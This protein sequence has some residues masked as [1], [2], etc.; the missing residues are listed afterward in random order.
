M[1][2]AIGSRA[3]L[4]EVKKCVACKSCELACAKAHA[5]FEDLVAAVLTEA[6]LV[7]RVHVIRAAG[8]NV[9]IQCRHCQD[10]PCVAACPTEALY[11]E[12]ES[13]RVLTDPE[14][15]IACGAC[16]RVCPYGAI[17]WDADGEKIVKCDV[18]EGLIQDGEEPFCV[19][20]CPTNALHMV[21]VEELHEA[22]AS[23]QYDSL[24]RDE[25]RIGAAGPG[26]TFEIDRD[27]CI[28]CGR[29]AKNCP[30][31]C[32]AGKPGKAPSKAKP[33]DKEKGKVGEPFEIDQDK[34]VKCGT[35]FE[36][37]PAD[38]VRKS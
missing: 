21:T 10:A 4:V 31:D 36:V 11:K 38:A 32:I 13:G 6:R 37:C 7:P 35:C 29:C 12:E 8:Q 2:T 1:A 30:V 19:R 18:C 16:T 15:C 9:P 33:E 17:V 28:C 24:V 23:E 20:A 34:C 26:V 22:S 5:G 3:V 27:A 25:S 14:K